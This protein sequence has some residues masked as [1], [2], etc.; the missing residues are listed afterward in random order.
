MGSEEMLDLGCSRGCGCFAKAQLGRQDPGTDL[1]GHA[2]KRVAASDQSLQ[3]AAGVAAIAVAGTQF[4]FAGSVSAARA[5]LTRSCAESGLLGPNA[6]GPAQ[7]GA[8]AGGHENERRLE[9]SSLALH[10]V[11]VVVKGQLASLRTAWALRT[12]CRSSL[13]VSWAAAGW[14][15]AGW[16]M[17]RTETVQEAAEECSGLMSVWIRGAVGTSPARA[18]GWVRLRDFDERAVSRSASSG[19]VETPALGGQ[20]ACL[21]VRGIRACGLAKELHRWGPWAAAVA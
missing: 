3:A 2:P 7:Q 14:K 18:C 19:V 4:A 16:A 9:T 5:L 13:L 12:T 21:A 10:G 8:A 17:C 15:T 11:H 1:V 20:H 6:S